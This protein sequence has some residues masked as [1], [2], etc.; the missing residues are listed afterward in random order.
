MTIKKIYS[1]ATLDKDN[2]FRG[3]LPAEKQY[4]KELLILPTQYTRSDNWV[5]LQEGAN[6]S[7]RPILN[8]IDTILIKIIKTGIWR[9]NKGEI[10]ML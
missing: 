3:V 9:I 10:A 1:P 7:R 6:I 5:Q 4:K 2:T 8:Q